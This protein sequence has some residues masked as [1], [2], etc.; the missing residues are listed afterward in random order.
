M[1]KIMIA[2]A[3]VS[4]ALSAQETKLKSADVPRAVSAALAN[5]YPG[6]R[7]SAWT[8][9]VENGKTTYEAS[10]TDHEAKRDVVFN[11]GGSLEAVEQSIPLSE[12]PGKVKTAVKDKY[13]GAVLRKAEKITRED[14]TQYEIDLGKAA[15]KEVLFNAQGK[16][17]KEE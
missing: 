13:P 12:L 17:L 2:A 4:I 16:V 9:E 7:V 3:C 14:E 8:K 11:T 6:A 15:K 10:I 1:K 5:K